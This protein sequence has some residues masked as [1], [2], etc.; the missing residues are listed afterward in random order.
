MLPV[1]DDVV[2]AVRSLLPSAEE[3]STHAGCGLD[4]GLRAGTTDMPRPKRHEGK[5]MR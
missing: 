3:N 5:V 4:R 2:G 1:S